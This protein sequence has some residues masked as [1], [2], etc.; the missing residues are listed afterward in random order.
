MKTFTQFFNGISPLTE[1]PIYIMTAEEL[2][3]FGANHTDPL[4]IAT[5]C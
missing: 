1:Y 3:L 2:A 5:F 4:V